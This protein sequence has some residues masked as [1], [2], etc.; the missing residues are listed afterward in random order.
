MSKLTLEQAIG[1][2]HTF[3][4][5]DLKRHYDA[6]SVCWESM[7]K[8]AAAI[9]NGVTVS[10]G[11]LLTAFGAATR[12][13]QPATIFSTKANETLVALEIVRQA[14]QAGEAEELK[15]WNEPEDFKW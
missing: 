2:L 1:V 11:K 3:V 10:D 5:N 12:L 14:R 15:K 9:Q 6:V 4:K 8:A 13:E 7:K